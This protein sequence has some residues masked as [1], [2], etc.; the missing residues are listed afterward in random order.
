MRRHIERFRLWVLALTPEC[1]A[2]LQRLQLEYLQVVSIA[3]LEGQDADL[4]R[5]RANR[6]LAEFYFTL[7]PCFLF[8]LLARKS[9][10]E[11]LTYLDADTFFFSDPSPVEQEVAS[12]SI[13]ITP[14]R[15]RAN[16][17]H[18]L[19]YGV[20][21]VGWLSF[22]NNAQ[23]RACLARWRLQCLEWCRDVAEGGRFADQGYLNE[24][25]KLYSELHILS[26]PGFNEGPWN[27]DPALV[28]LR[29]NGVYVQDQLLTL[30]HFQGL[31]RMAPDVFNPNWHDYGLR[32]S[33]LVVQNVYRP[34]LEAIGQAEQNAGLRAEGQ[35]FI[36]GQNPGGK[37]KFRLPWH[38]R[39]RTAVKIMRGS[40]L[41]LPGR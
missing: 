26:R 14:H 31:R 18:H 28:S 12:S 8:Y 30:F 6:S 35:E 24:W 37:K 41:S 36:R 4:S 2:I 40:Y 21:N 32:P 7:T 5:A 38:E 39:I 1:E 25:P 33:R 3:H 29:N 15:F 34:Y 23:G 13:A 9:A 17:A 16:L 11:R 20:Y 10:P 19:R 27:L 22:R